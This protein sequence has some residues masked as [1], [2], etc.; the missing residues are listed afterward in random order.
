MTLSGES[1]ETVSGVNGVNSEHAG[2]AP[3]GESHETLRKPQEG[4]TPER[5]VEGVVEQGGGAVA[6]EARTRAAA[7]L[8]GNALLDE[9][10]RMVKP[11]LPRDVARRVG[12]KIDSLLD[13]PGIDPDE[14]RE[15]LRRLRSN[16]K[17]GP[18]MLPDL[19]HEARQE[20]AG[21]GAPRSSA[22]EPTTNARVRAGL[23]LAQRY[24]LEEQRE[25]PA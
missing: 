19:V 3:S 23:E 4:L 24:A 16:R 20:R 18:G 7:T 13:D 14:I 17:W 25:L 8:L 22:S 6:R 1:H 15:G 9:H 2:Q 11:P 10:R 5:V 12:E 21:Q